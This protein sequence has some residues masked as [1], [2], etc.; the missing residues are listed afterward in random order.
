MYAIDFVGALA[1]GVAQFQHV[2]VVIMEVISDG[3]L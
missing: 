2:E 3:C 1:G